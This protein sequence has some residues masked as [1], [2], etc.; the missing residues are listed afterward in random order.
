[1]P[2]AQKK[3]S[4]L[5]KSVKI[6]HR[7]DF[8]RLRSAGRSFAAET[9][10]LVFLDHSELRCG[11]VCS[12][13]YSTLSVERNRARRLLWESFRIVRPHL[14]GKG[15]FLAIARRGM[16][17]KKRQDVTRDLVRLLKKFNAVS[18]QLELD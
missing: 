13:R 16:K 9:L 14:T 8:D 5:A 10:V 17:G 1:M 12:K 7:A 11:V 6:C 4:G 3:L 2:E 18:R 15:M